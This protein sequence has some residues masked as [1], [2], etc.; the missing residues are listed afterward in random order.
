[1]QTLTRIIE[2]TDKS[3][4]VI[5]NI[6]SF[7]LETGVFKIEKY[8][9]P[10]ENTPVIGEGEYILKIGKTRLIKTE[11]VDENVS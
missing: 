5:I 3:G 6:D 11:E 4:M 7:L 10:K 9:H 2:I 8:L 1:M